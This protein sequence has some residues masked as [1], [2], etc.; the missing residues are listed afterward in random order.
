MFN[1]TLNPVIL[2]LGPVEIRWYGLMYVIGFIIAYFL[3]P[4]LSKHFKIDITKEK[5]ADLL[6]YLAVGMIVF[7]RLFE[8]LVYNPSY[9]FSN[10]A[11]IIA[12]WKGGLSY[13]GALIGMAIAGFI[14]SKKNKIP[15]LKLAD[16]VSVCAALGLVF[17]RIGNFINGEL[18]GRVADVPW[19]TYFKGYEGCRHP[20]Q[21]YD[22]FSNLVLFGILW[23]LKGKKQ[24]GFVFFLLLILGGV[25]RIIIEQF[26]RM[27]D[28]YILGMTTGQF[29]SVFMVIAGVYGMAWLKDKKENNI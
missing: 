12:V 3:I 8:V 18:V 10:P 19:C 24:D 16:I 21:L 15:F 26:F 17:G 1:N 14:F 7:S 6:A 23:Q 4:K 2:D 25:F 29:L 9:Y 22:A 11:D 20:S 5:T 27:P 13:H 28:G